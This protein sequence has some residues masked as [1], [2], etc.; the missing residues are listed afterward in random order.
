MPTYYLISSS[1][2]DKKWGGKELLRDSIIDVDGAEVGNE[3]AFGKS[4]FDQTCFGEFLRTGTISP[5][6]FVFTARILVIS[7]VVRK[8]ESSDVE[9]MEFIE[10]STGRDFRIFRPKLA[11]DATDFSRSNIDPWPDHAVLRPWHDPRGRMFLRPAI[12]W[13]KIPL[14]TDAFRLADWP[15]VSNIVVSDVYKRRIEDVIE[16]GYISF[17]QM[18]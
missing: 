5:V 7:D 12:D 17:E 9:S 8:F 13:G 16:D 14:G 11:V 2:S 6:Q 18:S 1:D 4:S 3:V 10:R 15:G